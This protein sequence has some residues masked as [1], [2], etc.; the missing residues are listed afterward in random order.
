MEQLATIEGRP[1]DTLPA[2]LADVLRRVAAGAEIVVAG[3]RPVDLAD[4]TRFAA[5]WSDPVLRDRARRIRCVDASS[6][7]FAEYFR[8]E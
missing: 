8:A 2:L 7:S 6:D 1:D 3:T 5:I 4:T